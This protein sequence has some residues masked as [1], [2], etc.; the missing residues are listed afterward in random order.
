MKTLKKSSPINLLILISVFLCQ[1][2][3]LTSF[4]KDIKNTKKDEIAIRETLNIIPNRSS[5][6]W[7]GTSGMPIIA[8][9]TGSIKV[10]KGKVQ[11]DSN[12][13]I[14][15]AE[16]LIDM[17]SISNDNLS[18]ELQAKIENH[19][20]STDFFDVKKYPEA[21]FKSSKVEKIGDRRYQLIGALTIKNLKKN[22][23]ILG[24]YTTDGF[25][26]S[27]KGNF[28]FDRTDFG[29]KYGSGKF[30]KDLGDK[31]INDNVKLSFDL[32]AN[33]S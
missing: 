13:D 31:L 28:I 32:K 16:I 21:N 25:N 30:F 33:P 24:F 6:R 17:S 15:A 14:S 22:T 8:E 3:Y 26:Y 19:L 7:Y 23:N 18:G 20:K 1:I 12:G 11:I 9:Q 10:K 2:L 27:F 29:I 4:A 5:I